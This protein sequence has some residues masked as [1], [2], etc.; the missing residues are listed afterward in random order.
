MK[1][2]RRRALLFQTLILAIMPL[3]LLLIA[4]SIG[5]QTLHLTAIRRLVGERDERTAQAAANG[6]AHQVG[7]RVSAINNL[8]LRANAMGDSVHAMSNAGTFFPEFDVGLA[9][10]TA[11][12]S[13]AH[14]TNQSGFW[15]EELVQT[16]LN[17]LDE[18]TE[19]SD[20]SRFLSVITDSIS[21]AKILLIASMMEDGSI[22]AGAVT[23][24]NLAGQALGDVFNPN[25][26]A[27]VFI[28]DENYE[29]LYRTGP[30]YWSE[31]GLQGHPGL[32]HALDGQHGATVHNERE[33]EHIVAYSPIPGVNWALVIEEPWRLVTDPVVEAT[34]LVPLVLIP[35]LIVAMIAI[36]FGFR[37]IVRPLQF[38]ELQTSKLAYGQYAAI[39]EPVGGILEIQNL[40]SELIRM[41]RRVRRAQESLRNYLGS[42]TVAQ[43]EERSRLARDLHDDTIQSLVVL[44]RKAQLTKMSLDGQPQAEQL[45]EM[46]ELS[47]Q[48][49]DDLRRIAQDLRPTYLED[50]G[51]TPALNMLAQDTGSAL[52]IPITFEVS[53]SELRLAA[54]IE[55]ALYRI[56]QE[57]LSNVARHAQPSHVSVNLDY[58]AE[59]VAL[60]VTDDGK[61]FDVPEG[62]AEMAPDGH[63]GLLGIYERAD[64][65]GGRVT[66]QSEPDQGTCLIVRLPNFRTF[67]SEN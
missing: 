40:Q 46:E 11:R 27:S 29:L 6:L 47:T 65:I 21:G 42:V 26:Q 37:Q 44:T 62:S 23:L 55:L 30:A 31:D 13:L 66:I 48:I 60:T 22:V 3:T 25:E 10:F 16:E 35:A 18:S 7:D 59:E 53:G 63:Y 32:A 12:G 50:L 20:P 39:E 4:L 34:E 38:L 64:L 51:L 33:P 58:A 54:D 15:D 49:I 17:K 9:Q 19:T 52:N 57:S 24:E 56:A 45:G 61:G 14:T 43:E 8:S 36:W 28:V 41:T 5:A 2:K 67:I 1:Q